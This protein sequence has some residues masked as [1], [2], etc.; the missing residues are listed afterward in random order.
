MTGTTRP[1]IP[2]ESVVVYSI[3]PPRY[4]VIATVMSEAHGKGQGA[5]DKAMARL[6]ERAAKLGANG[7][8]LGNINVNKTYATYYGLPIG[9]GPSQTGVSGTAIYVSQ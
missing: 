1:P 8:I 9:P 3:A 6:K 5:I 4:D 2:P 7:L